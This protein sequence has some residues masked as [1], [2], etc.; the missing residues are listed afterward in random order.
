MVLGNY[1]F[2]Y[3]KGIM[4]FLLFLLLRIHPIIFMNKVIQF[5]I[6]QHDRK[7]T[8]RVIDGKET[9]VLTDY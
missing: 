9:L 2:L 6:I 7:E 1:N 5:K 3:N 4:I 8:E